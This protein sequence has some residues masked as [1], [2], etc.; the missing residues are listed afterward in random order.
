MVLTGYA[1]TVTGDLTPELIIAAAVAAAGDPALLAAHCL[2]AVD[3]TFADLVRE[4]DMLVLRG[5]LAGGAGAESA[6]VALQAVGLAAVVADTVAPDLADLGLLYGLPLLA[7]PAATPQIAAGSLLRVDL[8]RGRLDENGQGWAFPAP[9]PDAVAA[10][11][12]AQLLARMRRVVEDEG[13]AE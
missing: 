8:A 6:V 1:R 12:R 2:A 7:V 3:P 9:P 5:S 10:V 13:F 4:G 11:R